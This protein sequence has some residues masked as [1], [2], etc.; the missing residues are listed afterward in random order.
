MALS[1]FSVIVC[2][3]VFSLTGMAQAEARMGQ[4]IE[5]FKAKLRSSYRL[6]ETVKKQDRTYYMFIMNISSK[7]RSQA[8]GFAVGVT[9]T[10][11]DGRI[12][13]QSMVL[14]SGENDETGKQLVT[15]HVMDFVYEA[16]GKAAPKSEESAKRELD[17]YRTAVDNAL[18][19]NAQRVEYPGYKSMITMSRTKD[20]DVLI[21]VTPA[22]SASQKSK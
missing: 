8:P 14:R 5:S 7:I 1:R 3:L 4:S 10:V 13:G 20:A 22:F 15:Y 19:G 2:A 9:A 18:A 21:A 11:V 17:Q 6:K 16:L 12:V